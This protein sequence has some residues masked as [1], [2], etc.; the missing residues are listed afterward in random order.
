MIW[1]YIVKQ[2]KRHYKNDYF[3]FYGKT[4]PNGNTFLLCFTFIMEC[5]EITILNMILSTILLF[6]DFAGIY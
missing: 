1:I 4:Y 6:Y 3:P 2:Q 5:A